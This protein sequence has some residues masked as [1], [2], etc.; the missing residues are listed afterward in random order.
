M[1][2]LL[3]LPLTKIDCTQFFDEAGLFGPRAGYQRSTE[4]SQ[5]N[6]FL[7]QNNGAPNIV[8]LDEFDKTT[9]DVRTSLLILFDSGEYYDRRNNR[10]VDSSKTVWILATNY[11]EKA[12][13]KHSNQDGESSEAKDPLPKI[14]KALRDLFI[15]GLGVSIFQK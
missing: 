13:A 15:K 10:K 6:N 9:D 12:I 7:A 3:G 11:G 4:G 14:Q 5:L 2:V 1:H 8:F